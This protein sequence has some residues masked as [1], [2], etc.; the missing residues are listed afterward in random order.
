[1]ENKEMKISFDLDQEIDRRVYLAL[2]NLPDMLGEPDMS[3]AVIR[4]INDPVA[5]VGSCE[6]RKS[7]CEAVLTA[8]VGEKAKG[9]RSSNH[10]TQCT[11]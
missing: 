6:E 7:R 11:G 3:K 5:S 8:I 10:H 2:Q 1:M 4:F 9:K